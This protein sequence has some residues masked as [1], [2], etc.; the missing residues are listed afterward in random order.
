M[1]SPHRIASRDL[2][3]GAVRR[4][5][6]WAVGNRD[7]EVFAVSR[8][9]RHQLADLS[10]GSIDADGCLVCPWHQSTYDVETG[11]M[12]RGPQGFLGLHRRI[13]GYDRAVR[14]YAQV[15]RLRVGRARHD[16]DD[17]VVD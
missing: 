9:C 12:V 3:P 16:G 6:P 5:G 15:L 8:R 2:P 13:P 1:P 11:A 17:V 10:G 4:A 14:A 7:G